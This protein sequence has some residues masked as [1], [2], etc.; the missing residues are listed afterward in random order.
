MGTVLLDQVTEPLH[1][2]GGAGPLHELLHSACEAGFILPRLQMKKL[3]LGGL[4]Q[5]N[6]SMN[7]SLAPQAEASEKEMTVS[8][9]T[10][11]EDVETVPQNAL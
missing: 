5:P 2:P 4:I 9:V 6:P 8:S 1:V 7:V 3:R 10:L 11:A